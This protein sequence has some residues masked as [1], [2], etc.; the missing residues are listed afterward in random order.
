MKRFRFAKCWHSKQTGLSF[1]DLTGVLFLKEQ[2]NVLKLLFILHMLCC[3]AYFSVLRKM[4]MI[5]WQHNKIVLGLELLGVNTGLVRM[6]AK[7]RSSL[8][9]S[10]LAQITHLYFT[11]A[12]FD[13]TSRPS[14]HPLTPQNPK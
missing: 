6:Q 11:K 8:R 12:A 2:K 9:I 14:S 4:L 1:Q 7:P 10:S 13:S 5:A 3:K